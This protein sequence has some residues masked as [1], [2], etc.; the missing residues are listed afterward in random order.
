M[1]SPVSGLRRLPDPGRRRVPVDDGELVGSDVDRRADLAVGPFD[2]D[3]GVR[4]GPEADMRPAELAPGVAAADRQLAALDGRAEP[5]LEPRP[6]R[7]AVRTRL[8]ETQ[9]EPVAERR[10]RRGGSRADVAPDPGRRTEV[11]LDEVEQAVEI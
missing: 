2:A 11:D 10:R 3:V 7:I 9:P 5:D 1:R 8:G 6:D 4:R